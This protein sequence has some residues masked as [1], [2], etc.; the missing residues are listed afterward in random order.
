MAMGFRA[1][2]QSVP[3][4]RSLDAIRRGV[5][6][7]EAIESEEREMSLDAALLRHFAR[8]IAEASQQARSYG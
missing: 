4:G 7:E 3:D 1:T 6:M 5:Q 2:G 8:R